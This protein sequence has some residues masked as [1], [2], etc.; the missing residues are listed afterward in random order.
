MWGKISF[1]NSL[2][3]LEI[4]YKH[5]IDNFHSFTFIY[6]NY[7]KY[8]YFHKIFLFVTKIYNDRQNNCKQNDKIKSCVNHVRCSLST[9]SINNLIKLSWDVHAHHVVVVVYILCNV[10]DIINIYMCIKCMCTFIL[11]TLIKLFAYAKQ[12]T[13]LIRPR[14][15]NTK[16]G[17]F[18]SEEAQMK[19]VLSQ[20]KWLAVICFSTQNKK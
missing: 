2:E 15:T 16:M 5:E 13:Q 18:I 6:I 1:P 14:T 9:Q 20:S 12:W 7:K 10:L 11:K 4:I 19:R 17:L 8:L 3:H